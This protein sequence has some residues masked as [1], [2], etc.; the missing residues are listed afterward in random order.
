MGSPADRAAAIA[1]ARARLRV[2][3]LRP[4]HAATCST[5]NFNF[6]N[7][8]LDASSHGTLLERPRYEQQALAQ[9][10]MYGT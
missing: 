9:T 5:S 3:N 2:P 6:G 1:A 4:R 8:C 10:C 7:N